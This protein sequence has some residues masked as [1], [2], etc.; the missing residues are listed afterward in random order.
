M[1]KPRH[2]LMEETPGA[3]GGGD[4]PPASPPAAPPTPPDGTPPA[5]PPPAPPPEAWTMPEKFQVKK[6][7]GTI[8]L[9][10]SSKKMGESLSHLEK[11]LGSGDAPPKTSDEYAVNVPDV[12]KEA[13]PDDSERMAAF[14]KD[15]HAQGLTQKQFDF[16]LGKYMEVA[17]DLI[18]GGAEMTREA[19]MADLRSVWK[20]DSEYTTQSAHAAKALD[21]YLDPVDKDKIEAVTSNPTMMRILARVGKEMQEGGSIPAAAQSVDADEIK[22]LLNSEANTNPRHA[23]HKATRAKVDAYYNQ[24]YGTAPVT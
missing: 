5:D 6:E 21:G 23:D 10:A 8:D 7:D 22:T 20:S 11:R 16:F 9:E 4:T 1:L 19:A 3:P 18:K 2:V 17:P 15:A 14:R 24:K 12:W 13:F